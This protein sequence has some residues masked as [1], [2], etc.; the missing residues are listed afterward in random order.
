[1]GAV[2]LSPPH[3]DAITTPLLAIVT[4]MHVCVEC[5]ALLTAWLKGEQLE[6][7]EEEQLRF[8]I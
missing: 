2:V 7:D 3:H 8:G 5:F 6:L 1:M 4:K